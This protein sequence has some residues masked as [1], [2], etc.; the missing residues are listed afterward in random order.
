MDRQDAPEGSLTRN[1]LRD[2][3]YLSVPSIS[4][5]DAR[6]IVDATLE[7]ISE[8]LLK[9]ETVRLRSFGTFKVRSKRQRVGRNPKTRVEAIITP[10]R[11][12]T[13]KPSPVLLERVNGYEPEARLRGRFEPNEQAPHLGVADGQ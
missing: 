12:I 6:N 4:R 7:E 8:A 5:E 10:R 3:V 2:A 9:S 13:F 1:E 11:V